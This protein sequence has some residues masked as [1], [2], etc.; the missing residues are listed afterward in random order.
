MKS[1]NKIR[2][3]VCLSGQARY[4]KI[5]APNIKQFFTMGNPTRLIPNTDEITTDYFIHTWD[6]NTWRNPKTMHN[7][8]R[9]EKHTDAEDIKSTY[10]PKHFEQEEWISKNFQRAWDAMFYSAGKSIMSKRNYELANDFEYDLVIKARFDAIYDTDQ[11]F[12]L[13][14]LNPGCCYTTTPISK[15]PSEFNANCFDDVMFYG[16]SRTMDLVSDLYDT[17]KILHSPKNI[18]ASHKSENMDVTSFYGPGT[19]LYDHLT[20]LH[21]HPDGN[22]HI[23]YAVV[24]STAAEAKLDSVT[25]YQEIKRLSNEWYI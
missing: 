6:T 25:D 17:Y 22:R 7:V 5:A 20:N 11:I 23:R 2:V 14:R 10:E 15:F 3:A 8:Y 19:L 4:W 12:P 9:D 21:I 16:D 18:I 13:M 24:R 1:F